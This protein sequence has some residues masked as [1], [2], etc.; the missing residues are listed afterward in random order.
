MSEILSLSTTQSEKRKTYIR[1]DLIKFMNT[2][3]MDKPQHS[4]RSAESGISL[5]SPQKVGLLSPHVTFISKRKN[6]S[7][8]FLLN[9]TRCLFPITVDNF[10]G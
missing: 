3:Y 2:K 4:Q 8:N 6:V 7:N 10:H 9:Y 1:V 5:K